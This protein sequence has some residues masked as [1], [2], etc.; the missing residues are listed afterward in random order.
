M[1]YGVNLHFFNHIRW[2]KLWAN[3]KVTNL[4]I[5]FEMLDQGFD[6]LTQGLCANKNIKILG[7]RFLSDSQLIRLSELVSL[8][9]SIYNLQII[10]ESRVYT[11]EN[12]EDGIHS[13]KMPS[14]PQG[15]LPISFLSQSQ[16]VSTFTLGGHHSRANFISGIIRNK[17]IKTLVLD[18]IDI[19]KF[20]R[21]DWNVA[22]KENNFIQEVK[23]LRGLNTLSAM[24]LFQS[25]RKNKCIS[26]LFLD[27]CVFFTHGFMALDT[28]LKQTQTLKTL[29]LKNLL[30]L[31]LSK[32]SQN[33]SIENLAKVLVGISTNS[34]LQ[35]VVISNS[36]NNES[37]K[38]EDSAHLLSPAFDQCF[39]LNKTLKKLVI[40]NFKIGPESFPGISE[41]LSENSV[42][43]NLCLKGNCIGWNEMLGL[44]EGLRKNGTLVSLDI[45]ES[46][47]IRVVNEDV[48]RD[49][50]RIFTGLMEIRLKNL[51][52]DEA[53]WS[54]KGL[55]G[56]LAKLVSGSRQ[57]YS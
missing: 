24:I 14:T 48:E 37:L 27:E 38:L 21:H 10:L 30:H 51:H 34:T 54:L 28:L 47:F 55:P 52:V 40:E 22:F 17:S 1:I 43:Q 3:A 56:H 36:V 42:L 9:P 46:A 49:C 23:A 33:G 35:D 29:T 26:S 44:V 6:Y 20:I 45:S 16:S 53:F 39:K 31:N 32:F 5:K 12:M 11:L 41:G 57:K 4:Q 13:S 2:V 50:E 19:E 18:N 8:N 25:I 15:T 7:F